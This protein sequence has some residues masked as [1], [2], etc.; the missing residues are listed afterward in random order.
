MNSTHDTFQVLAADVTEM[1]ALGPL[2]D[3]SCEQHQEYLRRRSVVV[4]SRAWSRG[5]RSQ[6]QAAILSDDPNHVQRVV[7][8]LAA[9]DLGS[10]S[11][12]SMI[13]RVCVIEAMRMALD[14]QQ[15]FLPESMWRAADNAN[16]PSGWD[17]VAYGMLFCPVL[18][19]SDVFDRSAVH[20][21]AAEVADESERAFAGWLVVAWAEIH[22]LLEPVIQRVRQ[23]AVAATR[24]PVPVL[25]LVH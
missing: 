1:A 5:W 14:Q 25:S 19:E 13:R 16:E 21:L 3:T 10:M 12:R 11:E 8:G 20:R 24:Q 9:V 2:I 6:I 23:R 7:R 22:G 18:L 4:A 15:E 17:E